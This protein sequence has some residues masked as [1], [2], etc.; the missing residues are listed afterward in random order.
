MENITHIALLFRQRAAIHADRT[1]YRFRKSGMPGWQKYTWTQVA[2]DTENVAMAL[3]QNGIH[4]G[5]NI[6][7]IGA[8]SA[9]WLIS[10]YA[11]QTVGAVTVPMYTTSTP[12]QIQYIINE[13]R[14]AIV[15]AGNAELADRIMAVVTDCPSVRLLVCFDDSQPLI[16]GK[17]CITFSALKNSGANSGLN[18]ELKNRIST[19]AASDLATIIYTS[20]TTGEP[21]GVMLRHET[22]LHS[23]SIHDI[24]LEL[25]DA[26]RSL[27]FLPLC[28]VFERLWSYYVMHRGAENWLLDNPKDVIQVLPEVKP[29]VMCVVPR[30]F[31]KTWEGIMAE[32]KKWPVIKQRI[33]NSA[34]ETGMQALAYKKNNGPL[35][36][37]LKIKLAVAARLVHQ[38]L[39]MVLGGQIRFLP[40]AG[41]AISPDLVKFFHA[42]GVFVNYGY[43][44][45]ETCATVSCYKSDVFD[46]DTAGTPMP[47]VQIRISDDGEIQIKS[48]TVFDGYY[49]KPE[50]TAAV[51]KDGWFSTGDK[52]YLTPE[53]NLVMTDRIKD[54]FKTSGGL[55]VSPQKLE[56]VFKK[57]PLIEQIAIIGDNRKYVTALIVPVQNVLESIAAEFRIEVADK[58][59]LY[60]ND[61]I[62]AVLQ[63]RFE[64]LQAGLQPHE[65][66]K[67]FTLLPAP[68]TIEKGEMTSTLKLK[69]GAIE[70]NYSG[71][72]EK[73]YVHNSL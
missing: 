28:H 12:D 64:T 8:N 17:R 43:G 20:G 6:G 16:H 71:L 5:D 22:L 62:N 60:N 34:V 52:G 37:L 73:M 21:K 1:M 2:A 41:A 54:L 29:T 48:K 65:Q 36:F 15:F 23:L 49:N 51:L 69:R 27:C 72:I 31:E 30:F 68:F 66:V 47:E 13:A 70:K 58:R 53:G 24:R 33:F 25:S 9:E 61:K 50:A 14:I 56:L 57:D 26:D 10:D 42:V 35:P 45:T 67:R 7:I 39:R 46:P 55:Y 4:K 3:L 18:N 11:I 59:L 19:L 38:K 63:A 44:L 32:A 40:C